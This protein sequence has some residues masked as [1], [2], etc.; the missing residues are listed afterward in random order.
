MM[1]GSFVAIRTQYAVDEWVTMSINLELFLKIMYNV[2]IM[3]YLGISVADLRCVC[4]RG[5]LSQW[6]RG[7]V[8]SAEIL[9][10]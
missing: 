3:L 8:H 6:G 9:S 2:S 4:H 5:W 7:K 10:S 1:P